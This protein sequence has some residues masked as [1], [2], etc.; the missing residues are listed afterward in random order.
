VSR[1][2]FGELVEL[3][4]HDAGEPLRALAP[5]CRRAVLRGELDGVYVF[6]VGSRLG[7]GLTACSSASP[8]TPAAASPTTARNGSTCPRR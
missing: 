1:F 8:R 5:D 7:R 4:T 6:L 2:R 3:A